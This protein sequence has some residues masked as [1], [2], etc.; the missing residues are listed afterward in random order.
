MQDSTGTPIGVSTI[1]SFS[2]ELII[3]AIEGC[4]YPTPGEPLVMRSTER[5]S[6]GERSCHGGKACDA[7]GVE[8]VRYGCTRGPRHALAGGDGV[9]ANPA[10]FLGGPPR[11]TWR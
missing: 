6:V 3:E 10:L 2:V 9:Q 4:E 8:Y 1:D 11:M 5:P 7:L